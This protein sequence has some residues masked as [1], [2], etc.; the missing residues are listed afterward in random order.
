MPSSANLA[1][2]PGRLWWATAETADPTGIPATATTS[3]GAAYKEVGYTSEGS[4]ISFEMSSDP[5]NVAES[6]DPVGYRT[7]AR[8]GSC[9]FA[10][11]E[12]TTQNLTLAFNGGTVTATGTTPNRTFKYSP[13]EAGSEVRR[14]LVWVSEDGTEMW[15]LRQVFQTGSVTVARRK[16]SE[17]A[18]L[19]V[20]FAMEK[21]ATGQ[22]FD[23]YHKESRGGGITVA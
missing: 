15:V 2:G 16:G 7:T 8:S 20:S 10:M 9:A 3:P 11:A 22:A 5:V 19:P 18:T 21:P 13:P 1:L 6:L 4:E 12:Q 17:Y 14:K 23:V